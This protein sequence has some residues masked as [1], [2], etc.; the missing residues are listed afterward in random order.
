MG[1]IWVAGKDDRGVGAQEGSPPGRSTG[2]VVLGV[3]TLEKKVPDLP[4]GV[5]P[6]SHSPWGLREPGGGAPR[7]EVQ[8]KYGLRSLKFT[9]PPLWNSLPTSITN[10][11]SLRIFR[12]TLKNSMLN[13]Y[14]I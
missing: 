5:R 12:K 3:V 11:N 4:P 8:I 13:C 10:S 6:I 1:K 2:Q 14:S 7:W 9:S